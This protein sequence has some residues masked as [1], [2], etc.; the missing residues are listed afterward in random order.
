MLRNDKQG[1]KLKVFVAMLAASFLAGCGDGAQQAEKRAGDGGAAQAKKEPPALTAQ[2][3][4]SPLFESAQGWGGGYA[5]ARSKGEGRGV[6]VGPGSADPSV[7]A[8]QFPAKA[9]EQFKIIARASS[10]GKPKA[11][12]RFQINW[13]GSEFKF[14][15]AFV[16]LLEVTPEEKTFEAT[17]TAPAGAIAGTLYVVPDGKEDVVRY[18]EMRVLGQEKDKAN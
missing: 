14:I 9:G 7:F 12:G 2:V 17:V 5:K 16:Q 6:V 13:L 1:L 18:T 8:Q 15:T 11:M 10:V 3:N 4:Q